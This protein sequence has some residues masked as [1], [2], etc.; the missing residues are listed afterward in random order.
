MALLWLDERSQRALLLAAS[1]AAG[2]FGCSSRPTG[3]GDGGSDIPSPDPVPPDAG[4]RMPEVA[5]ALPPDGGDFPPPDPL[6]PDAGDVS[7]EVADALP[8]DGA[9]FPPPDP[10]PPDAGEDPIVADMAP[11]DGGDAPIGEA[12]PS[13]PG[14]ERR[15]PPA[16]AAALPLAPELKTRIVRVAGAGGV[17]FIART[18][19]RSVGL[20]FHWEAT[21]GTIE[22]RGGEV[23]WRPP[24]GPGRYLVQVVVEDG[25]RAIAVD[26]VT[27]EIR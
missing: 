17:R 15:A 25:T 18:T 16:R 10:L 13:D 21:G 12:L 7:P 6:P 1:L 26:A 5:D 3:P 8:P 27:E 9:D 2:G 23:T 20:R 11:P 22:G 4:D 14:S 19:Y 24:A